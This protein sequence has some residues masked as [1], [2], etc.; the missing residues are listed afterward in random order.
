MATFTP[1]PELRCFPV[2][3]GT[4]LIEQGAIG[5]PSRG[6]RI[7][8]VEARQPG[9]APFV[10]YTFVTAAPAKRAAT[11]PR[12]AAAAST[13]SESAAPVA[14]A[15]PTQ[16]TEPPV[17]VIQAPPATATVIAPQ[18][19]ISAAYKVVAAEELG[20]GTRKYMHRDL[21]VRRMHCYY[22][23]VN[24]YRCVSDARVAI[25]AK[26]IEPES[27]KK[28]IEEKCDTI[29]KAMSV[30]CTVAIRFS[31]GEG[32]VNEDLMSGFERRTVISPKSVIVVQRRPGG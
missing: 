1:A 24:D 22:A 31:Y 19:E 23:D 21:E 5:Q 6:K 20:I 18:A 11:P 27:I 25:F 17:T 7:V 12:A 14:T 13:P 8:Q 2:M 10:G 30:T 26:A 3:P 15:A 32:D 28:F 16:T 9:F 4:V 29:E